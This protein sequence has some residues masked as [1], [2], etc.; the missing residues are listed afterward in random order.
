[1]QAFDLDV[2]VICEMSNEGGKSHNQPVYFNFQYNC[3]GKRFSILQLMSF[4][5]LLCFVCMFY[6]SAKTCAG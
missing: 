4:L 3:S 2:L 6:F 1:M 5:F